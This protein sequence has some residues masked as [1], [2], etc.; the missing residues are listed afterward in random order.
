MNSLAA[1][2]ISLGSG[3]YPW[4]IS[5]SSKG[6]PLASWKFLGFVSDSKRAI[7]ETVRESQRNKNSN[8]ER[9]IK[10]D[11]KKVKKL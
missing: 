2:H 7:I 1:P 6:R 5:L 4:C 9:T 8:T 10:K 11:M 3:V